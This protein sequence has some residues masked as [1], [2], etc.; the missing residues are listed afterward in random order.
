MWI[1]SRCL[2]LWLGPSPHWE[3]TAFQH[4]GVLVEWI[5]AQLQVAAVQAVGAIAFYWSEVGLLADCPPPS[6][7][8]P[9]FHPSGP[10]LHKHLK[11]SPGNPV[12]FRCAAAPSTLWWLVLRDAWLAS[13]HHPLDK[14]KHLM[15]RSINKS[16]SRSLLRSLPQKDW[17]CSEGCFIFG[18]CGGGGGNSA[19]CL[20]CLGCQQLGGVTEKK[21]FSGLGF[22]AQRKAFFF[23]C[24]LF[25]LYQHTLPMIINKTSTIFKFWLCLLTSCVILGK[26]LSLSMPEFS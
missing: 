25:S 11:L 9:L 22:L 3:D 20:H 26:L 19:H 1:Q 8:M 12:S 15:A 6:P 16:E 10:I 14:E 5:T 24:R 13:K 4:P 7:A 21:V 23:S 2:F 17:V 18:V